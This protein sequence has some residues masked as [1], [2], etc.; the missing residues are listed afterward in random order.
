MKRLITRLRTTRMGFLAVL[1]A[2][3]WLKTLFAYFVDFTLGATGLLQQII[4]VINPLGT[5]ILLLSFALYIRRP[6]RAYISA[7][8]IYFLM[9]VLLIANVLYYREFSDFMTVTTVLGVSKVSQGLGASS[10]NMLVW[11]DLVYVL[12][13]VLIGAAFLLFAIRNLIAYLQQKPLH[14]PHFGFVC[15]PRQPTYHLP[16]AV[17]T[18]G[19]ALFAVTMMTSELNRPQLL[20]RTFD[21]NYI[22]KYLGLTPFTIYDGFKTA[23]NNQVRASADSANMN[24]I[25]AYT[26]KHAAAPD[27]QYDGVAKG[28]N[29]III[30]LESFQQ[31]L[32]G[33]KIDGQ[34]VTPFL[35]SLI[36]QPSTLSFS[37]FFHQVGQGKTSDA[38]NMLETSTFGLSTGSLFSSLGTDNTFEGQ[39]A[40]LE[41]RA[42]YTTA[43]FHGGAGTFWNRNNVYNSLGYNY[44]FDGNFYKHD[45]GQDT[46]YGIKD[47]LMFGESIKYLEHLQQ[48]FEAKIITTSNHYPFFITDT[49]SN[50]P[51]ANTS[52]PYINGYFR[53]AHY[54][55]QA[56]KEFFD[57]LKASGLE[58]NTLVML[59]GDHFGISNDRNQTLASALVMDAKNWDSYD[60]AQMQRVPLI[61]S[62]PGLKGGINNTYG[63]EIDVLPTLLHLLGISTDSYVQFGTD[64]LSPQHDSVVAFR[65][66]NYITPKYTV[67]GDTVYANSSGDVVTPDEKLKKELTADQQHVDESLSLSDMLANQNLLRFYVPK[68]FTPVDPTILDHAHSL[69]NMLATEEALGDHSTSLY[70]QNGDH[71]T[72]DLFQTD[73]PELSTDRSPLTTYPDKVLP[74]VDAAKEAVES[75][76]VIKNG[77]VTSSSSS[78]TSKQKSKR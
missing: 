53:T 49:D 13:F 24:Q 11:H 14:W 48:P 39:P 7:L 20:W 52:D 23:Q 68:G 42:G 51:D 71:S 4:L 56:L 37:N 29:V 1:L 31:F 30:H 35:N 65:N 10:L 55:D 67:L 50:F 18:V 58:K 74:Q 75:G 34:E 63:G 60:D 32:I 27:P 9:C 73:A 26:K 69:K 57:Y 45:T 15:D 28:K 47:K 8:I 36:K 66:H 76:A 44:F 46:D 22:V 54:L 72:A 16:Q 5:S 64:L 62:M 41:Q 17:S 43:V 78:A 19:V 6:R 3:I 2:L 38:E 59:Y 33:T 77:V 21:R 70:S 12:D 25:L 61:F 40:I